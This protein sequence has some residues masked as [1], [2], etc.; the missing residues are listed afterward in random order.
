MQPT[1]LVNEA[2]LRLVKLK[3]PRAENRAQFLGLAAKVMRNVLVD[4]ATSEE[5]LEEGRLKYGVTFDNDIGINPEIDFI[6]VHEALERLESFDPQKARIVELRFFGG[7]SIEE[8]VEVLRIDDATV[9][10]EWMLAKSWLKR[11]LAPAA[12]ASV[13]TGVEIRPV[14]NRIGVG[15]RPL[16]DQILV[17]RLPRTEPRTDEEFFE[18]CQQN[19]DLRIER[20]KE[21]E[22]IIMPP[23]G[24]GTGI[25]NAK[26][27]SRLGAWS[28]LNGSG[29]MFDSSTGF[30]LPNRAV[31]SPDVSWMRNDR[32]S[33]L[34]P[35]EQEKFPPLCPDFVVEIRS[36]TDS[37]ATLQDKMEEYLS[38]GAQLGWLIDP[39]ARKVHIYRP[40]L[41]A[42]ILDDPKTV[43]GEP[44]LRGFILDVQVL[45]D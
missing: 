8:T 27:I 25:R 3:K 13:R 30:M 31:R 23:T 28:D 39:L 14:M 15:I 26:L 33:N 45:W 37:L 11:E 20:T 36:R 44:L 41:V 43:V 29:Q 42:K 32:W 10:R 16:T 9:A 2:Y 35:Q 18:F 21:G 12:P 19:R 40:G 24:G 4:E 5:S 17:R 34:S 38:N 22:L 1:D 7:L 6:A